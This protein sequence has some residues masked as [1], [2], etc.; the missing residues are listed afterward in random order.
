MF[1]AGSILPGSR[2]SDCRL[3]KKIRTAYSKRHLSAVRGRCHQKPG[4]NVRLERG[5]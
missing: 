2:A 3:S 4:G 5:L 1:F